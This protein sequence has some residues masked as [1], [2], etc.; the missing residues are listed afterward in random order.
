MKARLLKALGASIGLILFV[1]A[2]WVLHTE[3]DRYRLHEILRYLHGIPTEQVVF[4]ALLT[5]LS[6]LIMTGYDFLALR[7]IDHPLSGRKIATASFIGYAFSNNVGLSMLAGASVRYRLYSSWGLSGID[8]TKVI[9]FCTVSIWL[10]FLTLGGAVFLAEPLAI[11][12]VLHLPFGTTRLLGVFLLIPV[13]VYAVFVLLNKR[14]IRIR[15][16]EIVLPSG[17]LFVPQV[18]VATLDWAIAGSILFVLLP[19]SISFPSF[20]GIYLLAQLAGLVSQ[21]PGGLGVFEAMILLLL[22]PVLP[23]SS[24]IGTLVIYRVTYYLLPL[25]IAAI[26]LGVEE[27][28]QRKEMLQWGAKVITQ[29]LPYMVPPTLTVI[30]FLSGSLLLLSGATPAISTRIAWLSSYL[31]LPIIEVSHFLGSVVGVGLLFLA[32][33]LQRRIDTAY[34]LTAILVAGGIVLSLLKGLDYEEAS[35]LLVMFLILIPSRHSFYR[36][37]SLFGGRFTAGWLV[38]ISIVLISTAW[39]T[40]FSYKHVEYSPDLW[41]RFAFAENAPRSLRAAVGALVAALAYALAKILH[42]LS[43]RPVTG[44][45]D[46]LE[47]ALSII[48]EFPAAYAN[49]ALLGDKAFLFSENGKAFIMYTISGRSWIVMGDPIGPESEWSELTWQ[50]CELCDRF[51]GWP[52]FYEVGSDNLY[53]YIDLGMT[54]V[55]L[56]EEARVDLETFTLEGKSRKDFRYAMNKL[57]KEGCTFELVEPQDIPALLPEL[58]EVSDAW[59]ADKHTREKGF[60]LGSF[61]EDY[62]VRF[63]SGIVRRDGRIVAFATIWT[64][65][66]REELS[67]DLMRYSRQAPS[68]VMDYLFLKIME[69]GKEAGYHWF[70]LGMAPLSGLGD[71]SLAPVWNRIGGFVFQY[72]EHFYNF[73]GLRLY[74]EKFSP[75]WRPRYLASPTTLSLPIVLTNITALTSRGFKGIVS[76]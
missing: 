19:P 2:L 24:I 51:G 69:W 17:R 56:G 71:K 75:Q 46:D 15:D 54:L 43:P 58:K 26:I 21:V 37:G 57:S 18:G 66:N 4:A 65:G 68:G 62:L 5:A 52:V 73:Q 10:G 33:G 53:V 3:L 39:L 72:A 11:P 23:A 40:F 50:F 59:I 44:R 67:V 30:A 6:Y 31:P 47:R 41:W 61:R 22:S 70:N 16:F 38:V 27:I 42:P 13:L 36:K 35:V 32:R 7:Y 12:R 49:L 64:S 60:S 55:K 28:V 25:L 29:W 76:R 45:E 14:S 8:I 63:P 48:R 20:I 1:L 74:K 34:Y 9:F